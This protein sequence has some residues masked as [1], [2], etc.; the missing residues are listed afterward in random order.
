MNI[1][2]TDLAMECGRVSAG[3]E[4]PGVHVERSERGSVS[5]LRVDVLDEEG[6]RETGKPRGAYTTL[7]SDSMEQGSDSWEALCAMLSEEIAA[8]AG[9]GSEC[10]DD[11]VLV[12]GLGNRLVTPDSI[13]PRAADMVLST[14]ALREQAG[15]GMLRRV[16]TASPGV[17]G[18]TGIDAGELL[19]GL[20]REVH[21]TLII[22]L[23]ALCAR[24]PARIATT[25]QL[26]DSGIQP[27]SGVGNH[28]A[29]LNRQ[30]LGVP[31]IAIGV[32]TVVHAR[33]IVEGALSSMAISARPELIGAASGDMIV[34]PRD[35]DSLVS[36]ASRLISAAL[37]RALQPALSD[38]ELRWLTI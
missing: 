14:R 33:A 3:S 13:G 24:D 6:E 35:I 26:S 1:Y 22:A 11:S 25:V 10:G 12:L 8:M 5:R 4:L 19:R 32:P 21:P 27:G 9:L 2:H 29:A 23:D 16:M 20:V 28:R 17:Y 38:A 30:S 18:A 15:M 34:A 37:N 7:Y 31:V 36:H